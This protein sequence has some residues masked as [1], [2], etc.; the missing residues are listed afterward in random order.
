MEMDRPA[1]NPGVVLV[2]VAQLVAISIPFNLAE[3]AHVAIAIVTKAKIQDEKKGGISEHCYCCRRCHV[4]PVR[5]FLRLNIGRIDAGS[6]YRTDGRGLTP[7]FVASIAR[8]EDDVHLPRS[9]RGMPNRRTRASSVPRAR[10]TSPRERVHRD[11]VTSCEPGQARKLRCP[12]S[13]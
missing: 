8:C 13:F 7:F 9:R 3:C 6:R 11:A 5:L 4:N 2:I 1:G 12:L 10:L